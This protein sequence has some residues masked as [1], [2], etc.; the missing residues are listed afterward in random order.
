MVIFKIRILY[1]YLL[2]RW[3]R[4]RLVTAQQIKQHQIR[5]F[6]KHQKQLTNAP[7][8]KQLSQQKAAYEDY[9]IINKAL[10]MKEFNQINT[11]NIDCDKAIKVAVDAEVSRDFSPQ[12]NNITVGLSSGTSGNKG[13]FLVSP[14]ERARWVAGILDRVIGLKLK[15]R[16]VAFFLRA[17]SR[18]YESVNSI[19]LAFT[20][21]DLMNP[22]EENLK[23]LEKEQADILVAPPSVLLAIAKEKQNK[24]INIS[25]TK[26]ISVAEV[27]EPQDK[28]YLEQLFQQTIH[29][30][31]QCTEGFLA[32]TCEKG[33]LH[34]NED[35]ILIEKKYIDKEKRRFHPIITDLLRTTQPVIRYELDDIIIEKNQ[36][37]CG[38]PFMAIEQIEGRSDDI[39]KFINKEGKLVQ[40]YADFVRR[41]IIMGDDAITFYKVVQK[42]LTKIECYLE[43]DN[44]NVSL[45]RGKVKQALQK[46]LNKFNISAIEIE[47]TE[48]Y[49]LKKGEKLKRIS[50]ECQK[51]V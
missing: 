50:N 27:L 48:A 14:K 44:N 42:S 37:A 5:L 22:F 35:F 46:M 41:S 7:F 45:V 19:L 51:S 43:V 30:V 23:L 29:Q 12:I 18:L 34:F 28:I 6:R 38:S 9:P 26:V 31:Y 3:K 39:L 13:V 15:K 47:F 1:Y 40:I 16:K 49:K 2:L 10:F 4:K 33:V 8:Y 32:A 20:F 36:C 17:N 24:R 11:L 25:P 21:F